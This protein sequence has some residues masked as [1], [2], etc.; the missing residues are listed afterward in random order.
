MTRGEKILSVLSGAKVKVHYIY[1]ST[2]MMK[3][4]LDV[5]VPIKE[6]EIFTLWFPEEYWESE[7]KESED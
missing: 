4:G 7:Y 1:L 6:N 3:N 2:T 5:E